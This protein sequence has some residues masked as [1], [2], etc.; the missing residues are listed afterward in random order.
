LGASSLPPQTYILGIGVNIQKPQIHANI[1]A[2]M[3]VRARDPL[4][5][6]GPLLEPERRRQPMYPLA[7]DRVYRKDSGIVPFRAFA[8]DSGR[9]GAMAA[10][11]GTY[12]LRP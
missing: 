12:L 9:A 5:N 10:R 3:K 7:K 6:C 2:T 4:L 11:I 8:F 1:D